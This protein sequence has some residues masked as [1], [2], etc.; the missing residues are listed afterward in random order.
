MK[1]MAERTTILRAVVGSK[2][3]GLNL[4][5]TDDTD[6]MAV[7]IEDASVALGLHP[8]EHV[9]WR[10]QPEGHPSGHGDLDLAMYSLRKYVRLALGGNPSILLLL[11][12]PPTLA[13]RF[14][15]ELQR[16]APHIVSRHAVDPFLGYMVAQRQRLTGERGGRALRKDD[17]PAGYDTK[18]AMHMLRLGIQGVELMETGAITLPMPDPDRSFLMA[19]RHG[20]VELT[21][22]LT[23][24]GEL[25]RCLEDLRITSPLDPKP[26]KE[27]VERWMV[28]AYQSSWA[29]VS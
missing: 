13:T 20:E 19:V 11:Y 22:V 28:D 4:D 1:E 14:G 24:S 12:S 7:F 8:V 25:E 27:F 17:N 29:G 2:V 3:H 16:L 6:E 15:Q 26:D 5:G 21:A 18:Y 9:I 10:T 23:R